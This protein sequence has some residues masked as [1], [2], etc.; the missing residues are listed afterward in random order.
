M[1]KPF[2]NIPE[3]AKNI[4]LEVCETYEGVER[5]S[6]HM[7]FSDFCERFIVSK[8]DLERMLEP[9]RDDISNVLAINAD[10]D[11]VNEA[12]SEEPFKRFV[13]GTVDL[14]RQED[15]DFVWD[16]CYGEGFMLNIYFIRPGKKKNW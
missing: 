11:R 1:N 7:T 10:H 13:D 2:H 6:E 5:S 8:P 15:F 12:G 9:G 4:M 14:S 3:S 16:D